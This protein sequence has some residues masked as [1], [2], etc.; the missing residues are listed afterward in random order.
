ML[1]NVLNNLFIADN[2]FNDCFNG[3]CSCMVK[4]FETVLKVCLDES[5]SYTFKQSQNGRFLISSGQNGRMC[6]GRAQRS[7]WVSTHGFYPDLP[8][9]LQDSPFARFLF[10]RIVPS[11][12]YKNA[13]PLRD[14]LLV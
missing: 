5:S 7:D 13:V 10:R 4:H 1:L 12:L 3:F 2:V 11:D 9:F 6:E 8:W 14:K